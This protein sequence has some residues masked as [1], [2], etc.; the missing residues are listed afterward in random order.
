MVLSGV[1]DFERGDLVGVKGLGA[2]R[3][4]WVKEETRIITIW[5]WDY[6]MMSLPW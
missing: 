5:G 2:W 3:P 6:Q 1:C 4:R